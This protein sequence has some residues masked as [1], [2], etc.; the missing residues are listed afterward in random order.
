MRRRQTVFGDQLLNAKPGLQVPPVASTG[1]NISPM[2]APSLAPSLGPSLTPSLNPS[3]GNNLS[4]RNVG[5]HI[6]SFSRLS[7]MRP[8]PIPV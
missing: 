3:L 7:S 5:Q 4:Q 6:R 1:A 2:L 8:L